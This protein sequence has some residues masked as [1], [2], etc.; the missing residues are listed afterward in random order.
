M[1]YRDTLCEHLARHKRNV[2][3]V[4]EDGVW[5]RNGRRYAHILPAERAELNILP[6]MRPACLEDEKIRRIKR[7][8]DFHHLNSSQ[9]FA[10]NLFFPLLQSEAAH[11]SLLDALAVPRTQI[12]E[13]EFEAVPDGREK[14]NFDLLLSLV[15]GGAVYV[16]VKLTESEFGSV[17]ESPV[18]LQR[19]KEIYRDRL[20]GKVDQAVLD[21]PMFFQQYQLLRN[22]SYASL[23]DKHVRF[24]IPQ[25]NTRLA[26]DAERFA[27]KMVRPEYRRQ[28]QVVFIE[29]IV[30]QLKQAGLDS[31]VMQSLHELSDKYSIA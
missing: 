30:R 15:G 6:S 1:S 19:R 3:G 23:R 25:G 18:Q 13:W 26:Q 31:R 14:T 12:V 7:H 8:R 9:A 22:A 20:F 27:T 11:P 28:I 10:L 24:V 4:A 5:A 16:E 29:D 2:L 17:K 21:G